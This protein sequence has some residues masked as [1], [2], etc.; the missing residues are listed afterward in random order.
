MTLFLKKCSVAALFGYTIA[1]QIVN[2]QIIFFSFFSKCIELCPFSDLKQPLPEE[3]VMKSIDLLY[4]YG[5]LI[6]YKVTFF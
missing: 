2:D 3:P 1:V 5:L 4:N 6:F